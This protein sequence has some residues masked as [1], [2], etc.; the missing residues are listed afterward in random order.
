MS[1]RRC[2]HCGG[3]LEAQG[4]GTS[5]L[6]RPPKYCSRQCNEARRVTAQQADRA[7][8]REGR[9]CA[10]CG[11]QLDPSQSAKAR[12]CSRACGVA[13]QNTKRA[14]KKLD[15]KLAERPPCQTCGGLIPLERRAHARFCS[16]E[17]QQFAAHVRRNESGKHRAYMR[18]YLYGVTAEQ[19]TALLA[20]QD[21][22]CA[23]CGTAE[24]T[25]KGPHLDHQHETGLVRGILC[26][27]CNLGLGKF[28]DDPK[29]LRAAADYLERARA[30]S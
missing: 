17:C 15:R 16:E 1:D 8:T 19:F 25:G 21:G 29:M 2:A 27:K 11:N 4:R 24:W 28:N 7:A 23:I 14:A 22:K 9:T 5:G 6:G 18:Q 3:P 13:W 30:L 20:E 12:T 10:N 26:H